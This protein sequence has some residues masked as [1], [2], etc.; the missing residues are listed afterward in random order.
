MP[1]SSHTRMA[2][3][4]QVP[5][6]PVYLSQLC[7]DVAPGLH[8]FCI[9]GNCTA[10]ARRGLVSATQSARGKAGIQFEARTAWSSFTGHRHNGTG[11]TGKFHLSSGEQIASVHACSLNKHTLAYIE[12]GCLGCI[13]ALPQCTPPKAHYLPRPSPPERSTA[14]TF[15]A[16]P[17]G[18]QNLR[19]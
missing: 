18:N 5:L 11:G 19:G 13:F 16:L 6:K 9:K 7:G 8:T 14:F 2:H 12:S 15:I 3:L 17:P 10:E 1:S 4:G